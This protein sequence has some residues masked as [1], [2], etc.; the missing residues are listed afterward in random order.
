MRKCQDEA[1]KTKT[2]LCDFIVTQYRQMETEHQEAEEKLRMTKIENAH[3]KSVT[4]YL[5]KLIEEMIDRDD[6]DGILK[7]NHSS[8]DNVGLLEVRYCMRDGKLLTIV[9]FPC[10]WFYEA[11]GLTL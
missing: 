10:L 4:K 11:I 6:V 2:S 1:V 9:L 3:F 5:Q 7:N 8:N